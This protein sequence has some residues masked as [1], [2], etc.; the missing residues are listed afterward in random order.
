MKNTKPTVSKLKSNT[1]RQKVYAKSTK[2]VKWSMAANIRRKKIN[3]E[4]KA[5]D[6]SKVTRNRMQLHI[7]RYRKI[8]NENTTLRKNKKKMNE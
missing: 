7:G 1:S 6:G 3:Q 8:T 4:T 2:L 5:T